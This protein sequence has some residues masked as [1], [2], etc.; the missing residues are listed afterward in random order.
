MI[1]GGGVGG[2]SAAIQAARM[3]CEVIVSEPTPWLGGM[4]T[5][6]GVCCIDG[7]YNIAGGIFREF[8]DSVALRYSGYEKIKTGWVSNVMFQ[9]RVGKDILLNMAIGAGVKV[10][11]CSKAS[12]FTKIRGGWSVLLT[13]ADGSSHRYKAKRLIDA[14]ELGDVA[15]ACGVEYSIGYD[16]KS[17]TSE[18][19]ALDT[20]VNIVQDITY[21]AIVKDYGHPVGMD[22]PEG[23]DPAVFANCCLNPL[24]N[25]ERN[26]DKVLWSPEEMLSY[27]KLPGGE[28]MLNW[29]ICGNDYYCNVVD[30]SDS[31]RQAHFAKAKNKTLC[32]LY[33]IRNELGFDS[34]ALS[35]SAFTSE[36]RMPFIPYF[37]ESRRIRGEI[38]FC[39]EDAASPFADRSRPYYRTGIAVGDYPVDQHHDACPQAA[40]LPSFHL[41]EIPSYTVPLGVLVPKD[42]EDL[43]V[44]EK[45]ISVSNI[46][47]GTTRLQP[48]TMELGQAAGAMAALSVKKNCRI[49]ET[50]VRDVQACLLDCGAY[51][52]PYADVK[53]DDRAFK[54][55]QRIGCTGILRGEGKRIAWSNLTLFHPDDELKEEELHLEDYPEIGYRPSPGITR[56]EA[57]V[58]IDSLY[59][60]FELSVAMDGTLTDRQKAE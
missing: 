36:D 35:D 45:S 28:I 51:L 22:E 18:A 13:E 32:Y 41:A 56:R 9:P 34:I 15:K 55:I 8:C 6:A 40:N 5:S 54:A 52:Q 39:L 1:V 27:G 20:T 50:S 37:R 14:T 33:F 53:T 44:A 19:A 16:S 17:T 60:P 12:D 23:Y 49:R 48:V 46:M 30:A 59:N 42:T 58:M 24:N 25:S 31:V 10:H 2:T 38:M 43:L 57:A 7:N 26:P 47:N 21:T 3:G 29:P 11:F 4:L